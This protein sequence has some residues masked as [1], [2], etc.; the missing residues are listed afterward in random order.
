MTWPDTL[1]E[2]HLRSVTAMVF[3]VPIANPVVASF[4][5][6]YN[7]PA[8]VVRAEDHDGAVGWGEV[9]CNFPTVGAEH[10]AR[11]LESLVAP[12]LLARSWPNPAV[13]FASLTAQLHVLGVQCGEPGTI[14]Q[15]IAGADIA[16]WDLTGCRLGVPLWRLFGGA[17]RIGVY[18]SGINPSEPDKLAAAKREEGYRAFK[19]KIGFGAERDVANLH[20]LR[21]LLGDAT[22]LMV[23]ANQAWNIETALAMLPRLAPF[24]L[25][26]LEE[27]IRAD[28]PWSD[29][30]MLKAASAIP[31]A[32]GEN[33]RG[34]QAFDEA[35]ASGTLGV[36]QP[37]LGK[38]GGFSGC[39]PV[40]R[41]V[42][43]TPAWF[44]P[45][46]LGGGI[47]LAASMHLK[48]AVGGAGF[49]EVDANDNPLREALGAPLPPVVEGDVILSDR[50]GL[51]IEPDIAGL[52]R[53]MVS[54]QRA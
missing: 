20:A 18:A 49:V 4:G 43:D 23:D 37:D 44:C 5:T 7:R 33:L 14:A 51:G 24:G 16:L 54:L 29:W 39:L 22:P 52:R 11:M 12:L 48:A 40:A 13:A 2:L 47:G 46:W 45:H 10:R 21:T 9:W 1:P 8:V 42:R 32:A 36:V 15:V 38:W 30:Q 41:R 53:F 50:P 26:W 35:V 31:L 34:D 19:L 6:M 25:T 17:P 28:L 3:R 27:P